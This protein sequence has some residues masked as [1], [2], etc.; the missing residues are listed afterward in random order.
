MV[1]LVAG[2]GQN[3][4][5]PPFAELNPVKGVVNFGGQPVKGGAVQFIPDPA[6]AEFL[7]NSEVGND[8]TFTLTTVRTTDTKGERKPGAPA[9]KYK[10]T[11]NPPLA[12]Q[13]TGATANPI[14]LPTPI[15][16]NAGANDLM[17]DLPKK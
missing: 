1:A 3:S 12:D 2:C 11:Y 17:I 13:T 8:G 15:T 9:G 16:V 10:V 14:E 5:Q 4:G 7:I 6:S